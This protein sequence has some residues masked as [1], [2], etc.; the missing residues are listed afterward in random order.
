MGQEAY[1]LAI[2]GT[3]HGLD[4]QVTG[5]DRQPSIVSYARSGRLSRYSLDNCRGEFSQFIN[6]RE[7]TEGETI[8]Q[9]VESI[10]QRCTFVIGDV[11]TGNIPD[12]VYSLVVCRNF[13]GYF[14]GKVLT[15]ALR[16]LLAHV[17]PHGAI[18]LDAYVSTF[19]ETAPVIQSVL[20][21]YHMVAVR[22]RA[23]L[24]GTEKMINSLHGEAQ[25]FKLRDISRLGS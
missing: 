19:H 2:L 1:S 20:Q 18:L 25:A 21:E 15:T 12:R 13:L 16:H 17:A 10:R 6:A 24:F 23:P 22:E 5:L 8:F 3:L 11:L 7:G 9:V 14:R 4:I